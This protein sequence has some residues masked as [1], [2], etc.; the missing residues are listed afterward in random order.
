TLKSARIMN[1]AQETSIH[2]TIGNTVVVCDLSTGE[3]AKYTLVSPREVDLVRGKIS[4][5]SPIGQA[6][7]GKREGQTCSVTAPV[8]TLRYKIKRV[9]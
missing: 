2:V 3:E 6:L 8:G 7:L 5:V 9:E 1:A 4:S